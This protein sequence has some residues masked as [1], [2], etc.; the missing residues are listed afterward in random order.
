[1]L[2]TRMSTKKF[3]IYNQ[4]HNKTIEENEAR[5]KLMYLL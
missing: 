5:E 4:V 1:M 3:M 2:S